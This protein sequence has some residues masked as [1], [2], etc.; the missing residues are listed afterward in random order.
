MRANGVLFVRATTQM[1]WGD[2]GHESRKDIEVSLRKELDKHESRCSTADDYAFLII[3]Q[4]CSSPGD[5]AVLRHLHIT[6][7]LKRR[8]GGVLR[9]GRRSGSAPPRARR[10]SPP[11]VIELISR[12]AV[13]F[14]FPNEAGSRRELVPIHLSSQRR[15]YPCLLRRHPP[16]RGHLVPS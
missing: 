7:R 1:A 8:A 3:D 15:P 4:R 2:D 16:R 14:P 6:A 5:R 10:V 12:R 13:A 9:D 11:S